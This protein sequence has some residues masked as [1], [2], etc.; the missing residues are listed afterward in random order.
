MTS[1]VLE[2]QSSP[3]SG[4]P[5]AHSIWRGLQ[6]KCPN[7]GNG[8]LFRK[9]IKPVDHCGNCGEDYRPQRADDLPAYLVVVIVGHVVVGGFL[10]ME[11]TSD[12]P[13]WLQLAIWTPITVISS[14]ALLQPVKGGVIALQWALRMHGF[15][16]HDDS[17]ADH[18]PA[19]IIGK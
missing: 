14:V 15:G 2:F 1:P 11:M 3:N 4:R 12:I 18:L 6:G 13:S 7:C 9:F 16:G 8:R 10:A 17:P 19:E 5:L